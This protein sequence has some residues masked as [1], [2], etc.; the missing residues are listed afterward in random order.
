MSEFKVIHCYAEDLESKLNELLIEGYFVKVESLV[1]NPSSSLYTCITF[2]Y[3]L[4]TQ[5]IT[6]AEKVAPLA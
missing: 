4:S 2:R 1:M 3:P 6:I 5:T